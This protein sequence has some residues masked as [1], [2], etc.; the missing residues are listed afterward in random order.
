MYSSNRMEGAHW[1]IATD[2]CAPSS[3]YVIY[4]LSIQE[5]LASINV[6]KKKRKDHK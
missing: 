3:I 2:L 5:M 1:R 6:K 4:Y